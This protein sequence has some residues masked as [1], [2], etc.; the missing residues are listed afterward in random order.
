MAEISGIVDKLFYRLSGEPGQLNIF[1]KKDTLKVMGFG[2]GGY[3][4]TCFL[5]SCKALFPMLRGVCLVN[6]AFALTEKTKSI[7]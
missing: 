5:S 1:G 7:F 3:L 6:S 4:A 2:Y